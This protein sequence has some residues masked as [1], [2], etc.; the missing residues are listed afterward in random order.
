MKRFLKIISTVTLVYALVVLSVYSV[1]RHL[2]FMPH[3]DYLSPQQRGLA[4]VEEITLQAEDGTQLVSWFYPAPSAEAKAIIFFHGNAAPLIINHEW[5]EQ[6]RAAGLH[7]LVAEYRGYPGAEGTPTEQGVYQD[8]RANIEFLRQQQQRELSDI[9]IVGHSL[10]TGVATQMAT[11]YDAAGLV[12]LAPFDSLIEMARARYWWLFGH[13]LIKDKFDSI[14]KIGALT[15][16]ILIVHGDKD[17]VVPLSHGKKLFQ[18]APEHL[19]TF[20][21]EE[22]YGHT[23]LDFG[24]I[25]QA[26]RDHF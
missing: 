10:G 21:L 6:F 12:L 5:I 24:V 20:I 15:M 22:G 11:E 4:N 1:H 25:A 17:W 7:V 14:A 16:P 18:A 2:I 8:A 13:Y 9:I 26:V 3:G 23:D 19:A